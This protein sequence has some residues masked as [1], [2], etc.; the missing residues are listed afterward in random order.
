[1]DAQLARQEDKMVTLLPKVESFGSQFGRAIGTGVGKGVGEGIEENSKR[2]SDAKK[3]QQE[4]EIIKNR[5]GVDLAGWTDPD[6]RKNIFTQELKLKNDKEMQEKKFAHE[7]ELQ[8]QK[9]GLQGEL[10]N[11]E[12]ENKAAKLAGEKQEKIAPYEAGLQT[13]KR[14]RE[15]GTKNNLGR[16]SGFWALGGGEAAK[17]KGEYETLGKSLISLASNI[18]IRNQAEFETLS[19]KIY[20][21]SLSDKEREGVL[22]AMERIIRSSM[23]QFKD[24]DSELEN[25]Q[26]QSNENKNRPPLTSFNR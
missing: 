16:G 6:Q 5:Y 24:G 21:S 17:D 1:M 19:H 13:L 12:F 2:Q 25:Q 26:P 9:Y 11:K 20:D 8:N 14:M 3:L 7:I 18:P 23:S 10:N 22:D 4:N 15:L